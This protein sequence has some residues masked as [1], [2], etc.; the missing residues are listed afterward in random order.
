MKQNTI[1]SKDFTLV[2][3]GQIISIFGNQIL[4]YAL[5]LYLLNET[6]SSALFGTIMAISLIPMI[7]FFPIGGIIADRI[8]KRNVMVILDFSTAILIFI[9]YLLLGRMNI[10]VLMAITMMI[11]Y[12]IQGAYQPAVNASVPILVNSE[13]IMKA[14]SVVNM[15]NSVASMGGPV[16]GGILFSVVGLTPILYMSIGCFLISAIMEIFIHIPYKKNKVVGNILMIGINDL[17]ESFHFMFKKR[18]VLW[19]ISIIYSFV[20]LLLTSLITIAF[21]ALIINYLGFDNTLANQLYGYAQGALAAGAILGGVLASVLSK[22]LDIKKSSLLLIGCAVSIII[23]GLALQLFK[24]SYWIYIF[25]VIGGSSLIALST[26]FQIQ[27]MTQLQLLTPE[28]LTGKVIACFICVVMCANPIGQFIYGIVFENIKGFEYIPF[29]VAGILM[30]GI[31]IVTR[32]VFYEVD[33]IIDV[34]E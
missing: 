15:I 4:R 21:P 12:G 2:V 6:G 10:V 3:I 11:L 24:D 33:R 34:S 28:N 31:S 18:P 1:F 14:N 23:G 19:K 27:V 17:K 20:N 16:I 26:L 29:Y 22:K 25:L 5:P 32:R 7:L 13:H 8:N 9:F 30:I